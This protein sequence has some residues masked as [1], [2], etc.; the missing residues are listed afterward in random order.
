M[1][2]AALFVILMGAACATPPVG[3]EPAASPSP[4]AT[5][6]ATS[7]AAKPT[8]VPTSAKDRDG[9]A[10]GTTYIE[11]LEDT[12]TSDP[13][14]KRG[15]ANINGTSHPHSQGAK[16]CFGDEDRNWEYNLGRQ[17]AR[18]RSTIG[19]DDKSATEA[20]VRYE[21][22]G[23][24]KT[25]YSQDVEFGTSQPVDVSVQNVLRLKLVTTLLTKE[26]RCGD[27][28]AWWGEVRVDP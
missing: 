24:G 20:I 14:D 18:F 15:T 3:A 10:A 21:I 26:G 9:E 1:R 27:A 12:S 8:S 22:I 6:S 17:Y 2:S 25:L 19:L 16:F 23:D 5:P 11:D 28:T 4:S 7:D 13:Y